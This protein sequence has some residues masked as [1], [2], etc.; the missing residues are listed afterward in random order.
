MTLAARSRPVRAP[1]TVDPCNTSAEAHYHHSYRTRDCLYTR[2]VSPV[3]PDPAAALGTGNL[4][5]LLLS[6]VAALR[7]WLGPRTYPILCHRA[8]NCGG[9]RPRPFPPSAAL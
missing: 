9:T 2:P 8:K 5:S 6:H 3:R 4:P 1:S 7:P